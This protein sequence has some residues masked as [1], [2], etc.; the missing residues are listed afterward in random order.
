MS[1]YR[2]DIDVP[3]DLD[4][5]WD[6]IG[7]KNNNPAAAVRQIEMLYEHFAFL[8]SNPLLGELREDFG[9]GVRAFTARR[10]YI[11]YRVRGSD[12]EIIQV[13]DS[14]RDFNVAIRRKSRQA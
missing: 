7:I 9:E 6:F 11:L 5:I 13:V 3:G 4:A 8:A 2:L 1:R 12:I 10:Y 14:V